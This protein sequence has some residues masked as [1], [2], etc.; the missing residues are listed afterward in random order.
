MLTTWKC[1]PL[2]DLLNGLLWAGR[3]GLPPTPDTLHLGC[4]YNLHSSHAT[5][6]GISV[7]SLMIASYVHVLCTCTCTCYQATKRRTYG[8]HILGMQHRKSW[9]G[10]ENE[11]RERERAEKHAVSRPGY[12]SKHQELI[13]KVSEVQSTMI[14]ARCLA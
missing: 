5:T 13:S 11:D 14:I 12:I 6:V 2:V 8:V 4:S 7:T 10:F 3:K 1:V 9:P